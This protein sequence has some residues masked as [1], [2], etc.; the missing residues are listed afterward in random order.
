MVV[1][2]LA[3]VAMGYDAITTVDESGIRHNKSFGEWP[4]AWKITAALA[5]LAMV[6]Q[7]IYFDNG[8]PGIL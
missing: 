5:I 2:G 1:F 8:A 3:M 4:W 7:S 6:G